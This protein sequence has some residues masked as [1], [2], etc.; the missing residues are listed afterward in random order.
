MDRKS[1]AKQQNRT[2][3]SFSSPL[4]YFYASEAGDLRKVKNML[5]TKRSHVNDVDPNFGMSA[6][7]WASLENAGSVD[8]VTELLSRGADVNIRDYTGRTALQVASNSG[9]VRISQ[10]LVQHGAK[11]ESFRWWSD[12]SVYVTIVFVV[13][14]IYCLFFL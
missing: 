14:V 3:S 9:F 2:S 1:Q 13:S 12:S 8:V 11:F 6:L 4:D 7:H 10:L 5:D